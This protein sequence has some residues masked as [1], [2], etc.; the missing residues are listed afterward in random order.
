MDNAVQILELILICAPLLVI[1]AVAFVWFR[2]RYIAEGRPLLF[3]AFRSEAEPRWRLGL[4]RIRDDRLQWFSVA[5]PR[6]GPERSWIR[7][8]LDLGMPRRI[9]DEIP[10][11]PE[12]VAVPTGS[13]GAELA[14]HPASYTAIRAWNESSPPGFNVNRV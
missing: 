14:L 7:H 9:D 12:A 1:A 3:C 2:R 10:G 11:L 5:G 4:V 13:A 8:E 6:L